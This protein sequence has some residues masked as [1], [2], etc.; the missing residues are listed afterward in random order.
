ML[1]TGAGGRVWREGEGQRQAGAG[2]GRGEEEAV[3][4]AQ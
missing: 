3:T 4:V 2:V 1:G